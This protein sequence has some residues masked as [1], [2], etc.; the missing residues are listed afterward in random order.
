LYKNSS[1]DDNATKS[2]ILAI[3]LNV[4]RNYFDGP[5][6]IIFRSVFQ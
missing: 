3:S 2:F 1:I 5:N 4:L 6:Q